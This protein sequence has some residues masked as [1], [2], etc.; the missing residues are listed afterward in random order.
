MPEK[1]LSGKPVAKAIQDDVIAGISRLT[2]PPVMA[3]ILLGND[4]ASGFYVENII[5]MGTKLGCEIHLLEYPENTTTAEL[6]SHIAKF[7]QDNAVHGIM[8]QKPLPRHID[9][10]SI[11]NS[12]NPAK[13]IDGI[14][15][16]NLGKIFLE[17]SCFVPNT[18]AAVI[19]M[20]RYYN[21]EI[22]GNRVVILGRSPVVGKPLA[23]LLLHKTAY[24]NA[25]VTVCHSQSRNLKQITAEADILIAAIGK[26]R[27]VTPE[28]IKSGAVCLDVGINQIMSPEGKSTYVGDIDYEACLEKASALTPVPGGIGSVTTILL[29]KNLL[30]AVEQQIPEKNS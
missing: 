2:L 28:M 29:F 24:G 9:E 20:I 21:I 17:Q 1:V 18:A 25:T 8:I 5:R 11:N 10:I 30:K 13:D 4:P 22:N 26:A 3:L 12:V 14:N 6:V 19:E 7:N 27:F 23:G 15:P 16:V